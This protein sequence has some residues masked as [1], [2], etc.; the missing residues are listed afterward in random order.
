LPF[1]IAAKVE[2][3]LV[4][5]G[6]EESM[7]AFLESIVRGQVIRR[8]SKGGYKGL[9]HYGWVPIGGFDYI[10]SLGNPPETCRTPPKGKKW[11]RDYNRIYWE[12]WEDDLDAAR[13]K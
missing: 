10:L 3:A 9:L 1:P 7:D 11:I 4:S 5:F 6:K 12:V 8:D 2:A 13:K